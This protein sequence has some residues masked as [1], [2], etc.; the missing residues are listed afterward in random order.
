MY[1]CFYPETEVLIQVILTEL[2]NA[3]ILDFPN[4]DAASTGIPA[5]PD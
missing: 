1:I 5:D 2:R 4:W 3:P